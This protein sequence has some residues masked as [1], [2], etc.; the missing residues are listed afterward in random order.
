MHSP[1]RRPPGTTGKA[2]DRGD[3]NGTIFVTGSSTVEPISNGVAEAFKAA[4]AGFD[5]TVEGPG[6]R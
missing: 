5:Y 4:N 1:S 2:G 6:H 3:P